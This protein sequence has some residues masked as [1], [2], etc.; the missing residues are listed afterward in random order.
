MVI[1]APSVRAAEEAKRDTPMKVDASLLLSGAAYEHY[2]L[3]AEA[4]CKPH[5]I[6]TFHSCLA[7]PFHIS[8]YRKIT[9]E[10]VLNSKQK[11]GKNW[12]RELQLNSVYF[13]V[14]QGSR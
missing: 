10:C 4:L 14:D 2:S 7:L 1:R 3:I 13:S 12:K 8:V 9:V 5:G 11:L 6:I